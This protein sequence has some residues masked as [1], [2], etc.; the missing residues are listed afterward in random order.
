[1]IGAYT[2]PISLCKRKKKLFFCFSVTALVM[3]MDA[4]M[5]VPTRRGIIAKTSS[6]WPGL[7]YLRKMN[8]DMSN[9][10]A[11][12]AQA[13]HEILFSAQTRTPDGPAS[14]PGT[15]ISRLAVGETS[16]L[17]LRTTWFKPKSSS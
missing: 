6:A 10:R 12:T 3:M 15:V 8:Y 17:L 16:S 14:P 13:T 9:N 7:K 1:M 2:S 11:Q 5:S 4:L